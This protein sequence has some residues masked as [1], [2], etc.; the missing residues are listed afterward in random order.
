MP[1]LNFLEARLEAISLP[2]RPVSSLFRK[3]VEDATYYCLLW[4]V[5]CHIKT[6]LFLH[7]LSSEGLC[8]DGQSGVD[9]CRW[10]AGVSVG[11]NSH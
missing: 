10:A 3:D 8:R 7:C 1:Q 6:R 4:T 9:P 5:T 2:S 11:T